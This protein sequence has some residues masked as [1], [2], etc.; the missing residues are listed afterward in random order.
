MKGLRS[1]IDSPIYGSKS[2]TD[3]DSASS[4]CVLLVIRTRFADIANVKGSCYMKQ[5]SLML[6]IAC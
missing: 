5:Q 4:I 3:L 2:Q 1:I 6:L